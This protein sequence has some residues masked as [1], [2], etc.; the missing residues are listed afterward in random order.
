MNVFYLIVIVGIFASACSQILLKQSARQKH[1][2]WLHEFLNWRVISAYTIFL[3][4]TIINI[5]GLRN[6]INLK[7]MPILE[8]LAYIFVPI[9]SF[10]FLS[11]KMTKTKLVSMIFIISGIIIF[12]Q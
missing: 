2:H 1:D 4:C 9:L 11:E 5:F 8:S 12:Y 10:I 6:G 7:D 3:A